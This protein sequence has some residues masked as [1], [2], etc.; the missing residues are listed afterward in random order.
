MTVTPHRGG[1]I[2]LATFVLALILTSLPLP[3]SIRPFRPAWC[4][5]VL[6]YWCMAAP[7]R[8]GVGVGWSV[9]L[10]VD[11]MTNTLLGQH[12]MELAITA[13]ITIK[14]HQRIRLFPLWQQAVGILLLLLLE[15][16]LSTIVMGAIHQPASALSYWASPFVGMLLWPWIY[17]ILRDLRRRFKVS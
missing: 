1:L 17:I 4:S 13:F 12:A 11:V 10:L 7:Q 15:Q 2:I 16:L 6:I 14:L 3:E 8:V 9:G 5:L